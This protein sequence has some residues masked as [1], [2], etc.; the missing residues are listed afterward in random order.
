MAVALTGSSPTGVREV[1]DGT[2]IVVSLDPAEGPAAVLAAAA[3]VSMAARVVGHVIVGPVLLPQPNP[4]GTRTLPAVAAVSRLERPTGA[5][6]TARRITVRVGG[7]KHGADVY[8]GGDDWTA[9]VSR[10]GPVGIGRCVLGGPGLQ[11]AAALA[12][13]E[14]LKDLLA[15]LGMRCVAVQDDL[16]WNLVDGRLGPAPDLD[17]P[18][19]P[20]RPSPVALLGSGSIGSSAAAVLAL[21]GLGR[22][23]GTVDIV[24][25]DRFDPARNAYRCP[26]V[27]AGE[28]SWKAVW[29]ARVLRDAGW[30]VRPEHRAIAEWAAARSDPGY[31]GIALVSVDNVDGRRDASDLL[32]ATTVTAGISGAAL[33]VHR[34]HAVDDYACPYCEFVD[35]RR[36]R[37]QAEVYARLGLTVSRLQALLGGAQLT[38]E[39]VATAIWTGA[40]DAGAVHV[41]PGRRLVD[42]IARHYAT[43]AVR[44]GEEAVPQPVSAPHVPWLAGTLL[45]AEVLKA[46]VGVAGLDRRVELDLTGVPLGG[47][48]RPPRDPSGRCPCTSPPRRDLARALYER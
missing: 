32:A 45:A 13:G 15:P 14:V 4:W 30:E 5:G 22:A 38:V 37:E 2:A 8:L 42:L 19:E 20:A 21:S 27:P 47:W 23:G 28:R 26:G 12:F 29:A 44:L 18:D 24:D 46:A 40:V 36:W 33:H 1:L 41:L 17:L 25:P 9:R 35:A 6:I 43:V 16:V 3:L 7:R 10:A 34:H 11:V 31:P 48:R 39:D